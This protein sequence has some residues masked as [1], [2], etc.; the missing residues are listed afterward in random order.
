[1]DRSTDWFSLVLVF[2]SIRWRF[3]G[4]VP[5][6]FFALFLIFLTEKFAGFKKMRTF[7]SAFEKNA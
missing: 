1:M 4:M 2:M 5:P 6:P 7:A 3:P